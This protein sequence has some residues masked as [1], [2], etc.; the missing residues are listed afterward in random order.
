MRPQPP[1]ILDS[2]RSRIASAIFRRK[3]AGR[4]RASGSNDGPKGV[5][6]R[7]S[8]GERSDGGQEEDRGEGRTRTHLTSFLRLHQRCH[9]RVQSCAALGWAIRLLFQAEPRHQPHQIGM[10]H[11]EIEHARRVTWKIIRR[12]G[13]VL[14]DAREVL[15]KDGSEERLFVLEIDVDQVLVTSGSLRDPIH[16]SARNAMGRELRHS[17][18]QDAFPSRY[19][20]FGAAEELTDEEILHQINTNLIG[21]IQVVRAALP[22]L[23]EQGSGRIIQV[24]TYGG[25]AALPGAC[26]YHTSKWGIE[27]FIESTMQDVAPFNIGV[28]IV[29]PGGARTEFRFGSAKLGSKMD[30]YNDSPASTTRRFIQ[31][32]SRV[33]LG[34]PAKNGRDNDRQRRPE[35]CAEADQARQRFLHGDSQGAHRA[36][37]GSRS[38]DG[39]RLLDRPARERLGGLFRPGH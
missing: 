19:G 11:R 18:I 28:T 25:Q 9:F 23:R 33:P 32:R 15:L 20:L 2:E 26:L 12:E 14:I 21:S 38:A 37:R 6:R 3:A 5:H 7:P 39:S 13:N 36:S 10:R 35:S 34:D 29:E 24:S 31:D 27:G 30:A 22:H 4:L 16:A 1:P 17:R 8:R